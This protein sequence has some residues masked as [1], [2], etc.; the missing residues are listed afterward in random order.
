M[1]VSTSL[2]AAAAVLAGVDA[3]APTSSP[4]FARS[5]S[6]LSAEVSRNDFVRLVAGSAAAAA[7]G[8]VSSA[9]PAFAET[10]PSGVVIDVVKSG[11]GPSPSVGEMAAIRFKATIGGNVIDDI[12]N[13]PEPYYTRVGS[14]GLIKGA[15]EVIPKMRVGDRW[16]LTVPGDLAFGKKGRP[17]SAGKP[18]IPGDS[19]VEFEVEMVGLP[20]KEVELIELIGDE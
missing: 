9:L 6:A 11:D 20:G 18:R 7:L 16:V 13:T 14:G 17:A 2:V 19:V 10:T 4:A 1:K 12:F 8:G 5:T 15:E 3:F